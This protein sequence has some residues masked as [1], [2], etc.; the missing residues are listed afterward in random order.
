M[1]LIGVT[2]FVQSVGRTFVGT[3]L[4]IVRGVSEKPVRLGILTNLNIPRAHDDLPPLKLLHVESSVLAVLSCHPETPPETPFSCA[5]GLPVSV[6]RRR[7]P[8]PY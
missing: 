6:I 3:N 2:L 8:Q 7:N 1:A 5:M 4:E